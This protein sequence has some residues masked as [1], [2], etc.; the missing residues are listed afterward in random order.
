MGK[1][2]TIGSM[3]EQARR[4]G[5]IIAPANRTGQEAAGWWARECGHQHKPYVRVQ[6]R[7][8]RA[9]VELDLLAT[10]YEL[11]TD[12]QAMTGRLLE[13]TGAIVPAPW[14][15]YSVGPVLAYLSDLVGSEAPR[16]AAR[17][18]TIAQCAQQAS[19]REQVA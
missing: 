5:F 15:A 11:P 1:R 7:R 16:L 14:W 17:L 9:S 13:E 3:L 12:L 2:A 10:G 4:D 18:V 8:A 19:E 6:P